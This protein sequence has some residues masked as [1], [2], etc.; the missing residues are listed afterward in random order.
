M[1]LA[2]HHTT[3]WD[4]CLPEDK[5]KEMKPFFIDE[6]CYKFAQFLIG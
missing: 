3:Q 5:K 1:P 2:W 4:W 6:K